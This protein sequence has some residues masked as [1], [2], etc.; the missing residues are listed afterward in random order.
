MQQEYAFSIVVVT[1]NPIWE[2]LKLTLDA[3]VDQTFTDYELLI[4]DDGSND[5]LEDEI[6]LYVQEREIKNFQHKKNSVNHGTVKNLISG[7]ERCKGKYVKCIGPGDYFAS[8]DSLAIIYSYLE[9]N[10]LDAC[11]GLVKSYINI[12]GGKR[13][14]VY[15][16]HPLDIE[17]YRRYNVG[18][19]RE[20]LIYYSDSAH[21]ASMVF[22]TQKLLKYLRI[23]E[24]Y[25]IYAEDLSQI[26]MAIEEE[27]I[28]LLDEEIICYEVGEGISTAKNDTFMKLLE[29]DVQK[30]YELAE[31][32]Y[33]NDKNLLKR[34]R[35]Q[36]FYRIKNLY[37]RTIC[38]FFVNPGMVFFL[39]RAFMQRVLHK[40]NYSG[41]S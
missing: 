23:I 8:K 36:K 5:S 22:A 37:I 18:R 9:K 34:K 38:R 24:G 16:A 40:H 31:M 3:I 7:L 41:C 17:A 30:F 21:G 39:F 33:P 12:A 32:K 15:R 25:V 28:H 4:V 35:V 6:L 26:L 10:S 19:I 27:P 2:K 13:K 11:W 20:N 1:Y 14:F 29:R